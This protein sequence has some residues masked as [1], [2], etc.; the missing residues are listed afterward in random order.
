MDPEFLRTCSVSP[1][2]LVNERWLHVVLLFR[3]IFGRF[4]EG[5]YMGLI[6]SVKPYLLSLIC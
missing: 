6:L 4:G 2:Q 3:Q 5:G 1:C